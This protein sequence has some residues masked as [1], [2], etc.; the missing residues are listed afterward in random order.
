MARKADLIRS[1]SSA[2][3]RAAAFVI[4]NAEGAALHLPDLRRRA[5]DFEPLSRD[6]FLAGALLPAAWVMQAQRLRHWFSQ[7]VAKLFA[8][9]DILLAAATPCAATPIGSEW[10]DINGQRLPTRPSMGLL[11]QPISCIGLPVCTVPVK[12]AEGA[13]PLGVQVI[14]APWRE[15]LVLRVAAA[16]ER[17]GVV[18]SPVAALAEGTISG[19]RSHP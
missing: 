4:T 13:L 3:A 11:T 10:I 14:A 19:D 5:E 2:R 18:A 9:V 6:R 7:Q 8:S 16:L 1:A 12:Q 15:D 17:A